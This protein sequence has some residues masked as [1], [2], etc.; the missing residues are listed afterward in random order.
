VKVLHA[1]AGAPVGGAETFAQ[2]AIVAL[3]ER[4]I[5]QVVLTRPYPTVMRRYAEAGIEAKPFGFSAIDRLLLRGARLR[6]EAEALG[7]DLVH[8]WMSRAASFI[9]ASMPCPVI[10]WFGDYYDRKYFRRADFFFCVTPDISRHVVSRGARPHRV[11]TVNTFGTMPDAPPVDRAALATPPDAPVLLV[12]ARMHRVKGID[13]M[14]RALARVPDAY[15]WIAGEGPARAEYEALAARL[16]LDARVRFLGWRND[17]K[18]LLQA[19]DVCVLPSRYEPF[20]TVIIEAWAMRKPLVATAAAGARQY[21]T[22]GATGLVCPIEDADAL[23][24]CLRRV[25]GDAALRRAIA[26]GG[27]AAYLENFTRDIVV[28]RLCDSYERCR[29]LGAA[30]RDPTV[31]VAALDSDLI[32]RLRADLAPDTDARRA[33]EVAVAYAADRQRAYAAALLQAAGPGSLIVGTPPR[34]L[35]LDRPDL[36]RASRL[37]DRAAAEVK[38]KAFIDA[39]LARLLEPSSSSARRQPAGST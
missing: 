36:E 17:R 8:A 37:F 1:I 18:A 6:T 3:N 9:P 10:G 22:D 11:F 4:G 20:G 28:D 33:I 12:L 13:T 38:Y 21:V 30:S 31:P 29:L 19:C 35:L 25:L 32:A 14:L 34:V 26:D 23:A 7:A 5:R 39:V 16:G 24:D 27:H 15:L 2:D